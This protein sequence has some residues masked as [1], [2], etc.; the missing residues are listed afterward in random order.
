M[1]VKLLAPTFLVSTNVPDPTSSRRC[2]ERGHIEGVKLLGMK[3][4]SVPGQHLLKVTLPSLKHIHRSTKC[5]TTE[6]LHCSVLSDVGAGVAF[7]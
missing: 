2:S 6:R 4:F 5:S 3:T 1:D 7:L